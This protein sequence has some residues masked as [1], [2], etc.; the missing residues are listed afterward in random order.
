MNVERDKPQLAWEL[1]QHFQRSKNCDSLQSAP[2]LG[3]GPLSLDN[4]YSIKNSAGKTQRVLISQVPISKVLEQSFLL[5][6]MSFWKHLPM[7]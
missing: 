1:A 7:C 5:E 3:K 6:D 4:L 2:G